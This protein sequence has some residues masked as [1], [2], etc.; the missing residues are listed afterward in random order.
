MTRSFVIRDMARA[1]VLDAWNWYEAERTGLGAT[2]LSALEQVLDIVKRQPLGYALIG[3]GVRRAPLPR[4]PYRVLYRV[5]ES[6]I[7]VFA[8][9]HARR[10]PGSWRERLL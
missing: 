5:K 2:F 6:E 4:F 8:V 9:V 3:R 7:E 1:D 10:R